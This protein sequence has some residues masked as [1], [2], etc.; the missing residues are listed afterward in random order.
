MLIAGRG[1]TGLSPLLRAAAIWTLI[2]TLALHRLGAAGHHHVVD[3][4][5]GVRYFRDTGNP[6]LAYMTVEERP[7][8]L[9]HLRNFDTHAPHRLR[10]GTYEFRRQR[11][12]TPEGMRR[13]ED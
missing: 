8:R 10:Q 1:R 4:M 3:A 7:T 9:R 2:T 12:H 5:R 13:V 6:L 11:E